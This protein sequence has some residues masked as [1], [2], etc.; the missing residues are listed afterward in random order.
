[1]L[2][3]KLICGKQLWTRLLEQ[4]RE[5]GQ[6]ERESGAFLCGSM[7][8]GARRISSYALYDDLDPGALEQ[9]LVRLGSGAFTKL[10]RI[11]EERQCTVVADIHTHPFG[12]RQS[13]S[14][15]ANPM[16]ALRGHIAIIVPRYAAEPVRLGELGVYQYL[17]KHRWLR[18]ESTSNGAPLQLVEET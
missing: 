2:Q 14:D 5:R 16:I 18:L 10:W 6:G 8:D 4:L 15:R 9:G 13:P 3:P 17:G 1:M 12:A 11:C 7:D